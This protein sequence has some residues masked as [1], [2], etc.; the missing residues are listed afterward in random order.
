MLMTCR[1]GQRAHCSCLAVLV[2]YCST[3]GSAACIC[4]SG[5]WEVCVCVL[6]IVIM[7]KAHRCRCTI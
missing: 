6:L 1:M 2:R 5:P 3:L 4:Y 7:I